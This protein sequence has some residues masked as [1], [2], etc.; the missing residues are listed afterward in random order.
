MNSKGECPSIMRGV[1]K[2]AVLSGRLSLFL[3]V[4]GNVLDQ[5]EIGE[6]M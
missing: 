6:G 5:F 4:Y 2:F 3:N 1:E